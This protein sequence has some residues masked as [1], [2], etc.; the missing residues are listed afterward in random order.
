MQPHAVN[1]QQNT[2]Q[3]FWPSR[4]SA[5]RVWLLDKGRLGLFYFMT[6]I[7]I[8][9]EFKSLI[10]PLAPEE[11]AQ[12]EAN[13]IAD[14]CRDPIVVWAVPPDESEFEEWN[15]T[16]KYISDE[17]LLF[18]AHRYHE[19]AEILGRHGK[20]VFIKT[21]SPNDEYCRDWF[22]Q[23]YLAVESDDDPGVFEGEEVLID[24]HNR[25]EICTKHKIPFETVPLVFET[26]TAAMLW[27]IDNQKGRRNVSD[28]D[29][30]LLAMR[31]QELLR[32][33]AEKQRKET[34][35]R[36][37]KLSAKLPTVSKIDTR[38]EAAKEAGIGERTLDA[39]KLIKDAADKGEIPQQ[40]VDDLRHRKVAIHRV[41]KDIKETRQKKAREEKR[42]EAVKE[43]AI[44]ENLIIGD[45]RE[46][47]DKVPD[48]S[49]SLIFTDPPYDRKASEM[50]PELGAFAAA[51]LAEGGS[52]ILYVG[53]TQIPAALDALRP[54]LRYWWTIACVHAGRSTV[55]RE[56]GLNAGWKAVLWFVKGTRHDNSVMVNDV[57]SGG[58]EKTHHDWQQSQSEAEY[59]IS[60]LTQEGDIVC[61]PFMGGGTTAAAAKAKGRKWIGFEIDKTNA[62]IIA[63]R[64]I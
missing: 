18:N 36:P 40:T 19:E 59:W 38:R 45:F 23:W 56:Y 9:P 39:V 53:Q 62:S 55:M 54:H 50:L 7:Q 11:Y 49:L 60:K 26:R 6:N 30:G 27:M 20:F 33:M 10:P 31:R 51:K 12:L 15:L 64:L 25:F 17:D 5:V 13:L 21:R 3:K 63:G 41:A 2:H 48:G 61:D 8:D 43:V 14:G 58:E 46:H 1:D 44:P 52:L 16:E 34:E 57:M 4:P 35:G 29:K 37:S 32:P 24:G 22:E 42:V 47:G 28:Y